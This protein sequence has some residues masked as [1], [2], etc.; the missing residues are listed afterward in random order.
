MSV[1]LQS[2]L[3]PPATFCT[4]GVVARPS[5]V[6]RQTLSETDANA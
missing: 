1:P 4:F 2:A 6:T 3:P 5:R